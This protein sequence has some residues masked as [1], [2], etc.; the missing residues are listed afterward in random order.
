MPPVE[1]G[2]GRLLSKQAGSGYSPAETD[3]KEE[4]SPTDTLTFPAQDSETSRVSRT[5]ALEGPHDGPHSCIDAAR[6]VV[7]DL[8]GLHQ[9]LA[10]PEERLARC[11]DRLSP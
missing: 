1:A 5:R 3:R 9:K 4:S 7:P 11:W 2:G 6:R 10:E 8:F